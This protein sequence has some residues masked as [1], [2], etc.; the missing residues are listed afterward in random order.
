MAEIPESIPFSG[1]RT[2]SRQL[3]IIGIALVQSSLQSILEHQ[4]AGSSPDG[5]DAAEAVPR[6]KGTLGGARSNTEII[7]RNLSA[8]VSPA[9]ISVLNTIR[10]ASSSDD[11]VKAPS[12]ASWRDVILFGLPV[13]V[14]VG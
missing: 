11:D 8:K 14:P 3:L 4:E 10:D 6:Q 1:P 7:P 13:S 12:L 9:V 2:V 5:P